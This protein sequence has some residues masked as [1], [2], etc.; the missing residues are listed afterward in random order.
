MPRLD[1]AEVEVDFL[2]FLAVYGS[3]ETQHAVGCGVLRAYVDHEVVFLEY[4]ALAL[5][6][7]ALVVEGVDV[8]KVGLTL[9]FYRH[10][11]NLGVGVVVFAQGVA[12]PVEVEEQAAHVAVA[13]EY[14]TE[15]V[16]D[17]ALVETGNVPHVFYRVNPWFLAV[18]TGKHLHAD[19]LVGGRRH[20]V[21]NSA[22]ALGPVHAYHGNAVVEF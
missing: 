6:E 21:V 13:H 18:A 14:D 3:A 1:I 17:L 22:E 10:G 7:F 16:V 4:A 2:D 9:V 20:Q 8:G 11:V 19:Y 12:Y 5:Y 15:E